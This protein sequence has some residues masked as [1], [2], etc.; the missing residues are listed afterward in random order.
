MARWAAVRRLL[1][2]QQERVWSWAI[3]GCVL[4]FVAAVRF[5]LRDLPLE[6]DEGEFAYGG[7][8]L[9]QGILPGHLLYT[10]K[11]PGTHTAYA[12]LMA[13]FGQ[14]C[15]G[16]HLGFLVVNC[17]T[18]ALVFLFARTLAGALAG[19]VA[20]AS[21][22]L[23]SLSGDAL[24]MAAHATHFVV[25]LALA[26][27]LLLWRASKTGRLAAYF[28]SGFLLSSSVLMKHN[29]LLFAAFGSAWLIWLGCSR[30]LGPNR[31]FLKA[32][33][34]FC[35]GMGA[36]FLLLLL[37]LW[38]AHTLEN[39]WFWSVTCARAYA[40]ANPGIILTWRMLTQRMPS[41]MQL[42]FYAGFFGLAALWLKR[43]S[44]P[45]AVCASG[46]LLFSM[47]AVIPGWYFRPHYYVLLMPVLALLTG[48]VV[49]QAT[50][51]LRGYR[52]KVLAA[53][54][55]LVFALFLAKGIAR[56]RTLFFQL[57]PLQACHSLYGSELFPEALTLAD[58]I[59][60]HSPAE[61]RVAVLGSEPE[62][63]FYAHRRS[64]TGYVYTYPLTE[65]QPFALQMRQQM[66]QEIEAA[67]PQFLVQVRTWTSWRPR[68]GSLQQ[69]AELCDAL[70]PPDYQL[71]ATCDVDP[72][73]SR[74]VWHWPPEVPKTP[75]SPSSELLVF[76]RK[77]PAETTGPANRPAD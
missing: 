8:L 32:G 19:P 64:A 70:T 12:L 25:L 9:L 16:V 60:T 49:E 50:D 68:P 40:R 38:R 3:L 33:S 72:N 24:G 22:A 43:S 23:L 17:V 71:I 55:I 27:L 39:C 57:S 44:W 41:S 77:T 4:L 20:A 21:Y 36:P 76:E 14:S 28:G 56:E 52:F 13:L 67:Q 74:A 69:I 61:A 42:P 65:H 35:L 6:R 54:P 75:P 7:Q 63:Y 29:G 59:R 15:A 46:F 18:I 66:R 62:I 10:M 5:R 34:A 1:S 37:V 2:G 47:L 51:L 73:Q 31:S 11:L 45:A 48:T 58:Y 30:G 26:G 53:A